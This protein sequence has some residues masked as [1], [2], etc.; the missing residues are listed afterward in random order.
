MHGLGLDWLFAGEGFCVQALRM[1]SASASVS[2]SEGGSGG[3][4]EKRRTLTVERPFCECSVLA[5]VLAK[6][7]LNDSFGVKS[8]RAAPPLG[9][10]RFFRASR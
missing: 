4:V 2:T 3:G 10:L 9:S 1:E 5:L 6:V 8:R 7:I